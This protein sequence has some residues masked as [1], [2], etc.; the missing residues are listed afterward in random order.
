MVTD[1]PTI[2][3]AAA[4]NPLFI[5]GSKS[6]NGDQTHLVLGDGRINSYNKNG[7]IINT[8]YS[9]DQE[10]FG[11]FNT[12]ENIVLIESSSSFLDRDLV[13]YFRQSVLKSKG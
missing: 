3:V 13:V 10:S 5:D 4:N 8:I 7:N 6:D 2:P 9:K 12:Q 11:K 1:A